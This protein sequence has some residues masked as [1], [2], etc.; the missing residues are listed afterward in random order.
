LSDH[1]AVV[2]TEPDGKSDR[3]RKREKELGI[4]KPFICGEN[5]TSPFS[6]HYPHHFLETLVA[7]QGK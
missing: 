4:H 7:S 1:Y 5:L 3:K 6:S 2:D